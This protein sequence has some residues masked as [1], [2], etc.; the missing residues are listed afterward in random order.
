MVIGIGFNHKL[1]GDTDS[2][3]VFGYSA[4][5][6]RNPTE[7]VD[8]IHYIRFAQ[9]KAPRKNLTPGSVVDSRVINPKLC[10]FFLISHSEIKGTV[11]TSKYVILYGDLNNNMDYFER[12]SNLLAY[13]YQIVSLPT[14]FPAPIYIANQYAEREIFFL[15][16]GSPCW[17]LPPC[18][19]SGSKSEIKGVKNANVAYF[20]ASMSS[21]NKGI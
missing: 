20:V 13:Y 11:T 7:F 1:S 8:D 3:S 6:R 12:L 19:I 18:K 9:N 2:L 5:T 17:N 16:Y 4:N 10:E 15:N 14:S 21:H